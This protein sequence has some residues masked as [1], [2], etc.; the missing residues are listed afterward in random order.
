MAA[1][2]FKVFNTGDV[3]TS[4][5]VNNYLMLQT[6]MVFANAAARTTALSSVLAAGLCS[7]L[8][9]TNVIEVYTGS[10]WS[11]LDDPNAIQNAI[12]TAKGDLIAATA[13]STPARLAIG[14][15]AQVLTADSTA[16]TG[17]KWATPAAA[18]SGL[19]LVTAQTIGS[20]VSSVTVSS[21]FSSTYDNYLVTISG[22]TASASG[23]LKLQLGSTT[24]GY[25]TWLLYG[26]YSGA[27]VNGFNQSNTAF[28]GDFGYASANGL[29]GVG[30]ILAPNLAARTSWNM[31]Y[32][33]Q[34]TTYYA[35]WQNGFVNNTT[36]YTA[37]TLTTGSG[38]LTGGTIR[39]YGYQNS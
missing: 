32:A 15:N 27:T 26:S 4:G 25:Y 34:D 31:A 22:G 29:T 12:V 9:D 16:A 30:T 10:A 38:T 35:G 18:T 2:G 39:V 28:A 24:S 7:Y 17:M 6:V 11:S 23:G 1:S 33:S 13:A 3:L 20:A 8:K 36:Q 5:D 21:V 37:F 19:T 14:T